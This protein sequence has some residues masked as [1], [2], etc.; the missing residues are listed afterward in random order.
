MAQAPSCTLANLAAKGK[1]QGGVILL[2]DG[3]V[4]R[5]TLSVTRLAVGG[6]S[7]VLPEGVILN[8][9]WMGWLQV[10]SLRGVASRTRMTA[11][12]LPLCRHLC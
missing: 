3:T 2:S 11:K 10:A 9:S 8:D 6:V 12:L 4:T 7:E 1:P 5:P